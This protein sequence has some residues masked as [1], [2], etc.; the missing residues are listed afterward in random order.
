MVIE[1]ERNEERGKRVFY[2][3]LGVFDIHCLT[4]LILICTFA[5]AMSNWV[6]YEYSAWEIPF[7]FSLSTCFQFLIFDV[8]RKIYKANC[9]A[10]SQEWMGRGSKERQGTY[11]GQNVHLKRFLLSIYSRLLC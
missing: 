1:G 6:D 11:E 8:Q 2:V 7:S 5:F 9:S 4:S 3:F 10:N